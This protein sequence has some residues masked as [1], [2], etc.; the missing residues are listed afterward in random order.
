MKRRPAPAAGGAAAPAAFTAAWLARR[1]RQLAGPLAGARFC[2]A[3]SGGVDSA[4]LLVAAAAVRRRCR[5]ELRALHVNHH[6]QPGADAWARAARAAARGLDVRC[7]V[8]DVTVSPP[9]G[10]SLEAAAREARYR[11]LRAALRPGEWL[12]LA[13]HQDDQAETVLLQLLRG[14]GIAGIAAMPARADSLLR[15]LLDATREQLQAYLR[16]RAVAWIEDPSNTDER[17]DRNYLRHRVLPLLRARWPGT[18][19]TLG[20]TAALAAEAQ[21]LLA[22][23][24]DAQLLPAQDGAALR[25]AVLNRLGPAERHNA[26]RR[27]LERRGLPMPD[28]RRLQEICGP[29]LRARQDA[30]PSVHWPG[31]LV[32]RHGQRLHAGSEPAVSAAAPARWAWLQER[33]LRL[34]DGGRLELRADR[35]GD[36]L[37]AQL[38]A[39]VTVRFRGP[40]GRV[41]AAA[42]GKR[43]KRLLQARGVPPWQRAAVP[44]LYQGRRL[45][46]V[47][48]LWRAPQLSGAPAASPAAAESP[49]ESAGQSAR[50]SG[51]ERLRLKWLPAGAPPR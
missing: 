8:L 47:A 49:G 18:N 23:M 39:Q 38:P 28:Q 42:G 48:D 10:A 12:L 37:R 1:L 40:D 13:Q 26:V 20:R 6:L 24:A 31:A 11:A 15:P 34:P 2:V 33:A 32:R 16:R 5:F 22:A 21:R 3:F 29:L 35:H 4:A 45:I 7:Q 25:V 46:A 17:F 14:A 41:G 19:A 30:Q 27:W 44:L 9:R 36:L 50:Q 43:L 51:G